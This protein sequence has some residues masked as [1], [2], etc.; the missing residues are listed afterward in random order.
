[1]SGSQS[2]RGDEA[3]FGYIDWE[4]WGESRGGNTDV[5]VTG[6]GAG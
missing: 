5:E 6:C 3:A 1:M 4:V 2:S